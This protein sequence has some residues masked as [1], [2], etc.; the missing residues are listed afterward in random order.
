MRTLFRRVERACR[1]AQQIAETLPGH[2]R[3]SE[4]FYPGLPNHPGH[5]VAARQM[6]GGFGGMLSIRVQAV[7]QRPLPWRLVSRFGNALLRS[8]GSKA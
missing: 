3:V 7:L 8:A 5:A 4:V 1:S 6:R 2:P